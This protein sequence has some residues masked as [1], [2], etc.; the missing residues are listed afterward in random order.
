MSVFRLAG[1]GALAK[2]MADKVHRG[3]SPPP[4]ALAR[5]SPILS[6]ALALAACAGG[7]ESPRQQ[8]VWVTDGQP[9]DCISRSQVRWVRFVDDRTIDFEMTGRRAYRNALPFRCTDLMFTGSAGFNALNRAMRFN[10]PT[11][12]LCRNDR[13]TPR[14]SGPGTRRATDSLAGTC[15]LG[16]FQPLVRAPVP[17]SPEQPPAQSIRSDPFASTSGSP[18]P[19]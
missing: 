7:D 17:M 9:V 6:L 15:Q 4:M 18:G 8:A 1:A 3:R 14:T 10:R 5:F 12:F 19:F 2:A 11:G 13:F 16:S